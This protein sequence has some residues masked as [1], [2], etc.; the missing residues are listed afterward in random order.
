MVGAE[1]GMTDWQIWSLLS[2]FSLFNSFLGMETLKERLKTA[3]PPAK[4]G[5]PFRGD[6]RSTIGAHHVRT[7]VDEIDLRL[8][9]MCQKT[10]FSSISMQAK[11][12]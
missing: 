8:E 12:N 4:L 3:A 2:S 1:F 9:V 7:C 5:E 11:A 10:V 6:N